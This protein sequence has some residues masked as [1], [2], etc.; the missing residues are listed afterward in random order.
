MKIFKN[1]Y[2]YLLLCMVCVSSV[3][4]EQNYYEI[5]SV[6]PTASQQEIIDAYRRLAIQHHP[7][8]GGSDEKMAEIN[9]AYIVLKDSKHRKEYDELLQ[10]KSNIPEG[11]NL[12]AELKAKMAR[13]TF[14]SAY[15]TAVG[16][17]ANPMTKQSAFITIARMGLELN[18]RQVRAI[19]H[20]VTLGIANEHEIVRLAAIQ[21]LAQYVDQLFVEDI[22][23]LLLLSS[24]MNKQDDRRL[25]EGRQ[26]K[27]FAMFRSSR[28]SSSAGKAITAQGDQNKDI[29]AH[30]GQEEAT[31][32]LG[33]KK[34]AENI[35]KQWFENHF[36]NPV[37]IS[38]ILGVI[39]NFD[40]YK[41][42]NVDYKGLREF[43]LQTIEGEESYIE[44][45]NS[46]HIQQL[47]EFEGSLKVRHIKYKLKVR[48][49]ISKWNRKYQSQNTALVEYSESRNLIRHIEE[50][51]E[52]KTDPV[53]YRITGVS[54]SI[55]YLGNNSDLP[56]ERIQQ[57]V[58]YTL[59]YVLTYQEGWNF[60]KYLVRHF[61]KLDMTK[62]L[63]TLI[64]LSGTSL[65]EPLTLVQSY[66]A[67]FSQQHFI[68][69]LYQ[70]MPFY[71]SR[72]GIRHGY[73]MLKAMWEYLDDSHKAQTVYVLKHLPVK[74]VQDGENFISIAENYL[75]EEDRRNIRGQ[76][77]AL[78]DNRASG[79]GGKACSKE[80]KQL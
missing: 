28:T 6:L 25:D 33:I 80:V 20:I 75:S 67:Y 79:G 61:P 14:Y 5:L 19:L 54:S 4:S 64:G 66:G 43:A 37:H 76:G 8:R 36:A 46:D 49:I 9:V 70:L 31:L 69:L 47:Q 57:I 56:V 71:Q 78:E 7:D 41:D 42:T 58:D 55:D 77:R 26:K 48:G 1:F 11:F 45:L 21:A 72:N 35:A 74:D 30:E 32:E 50:T 40:E 3:S 73:R 15:S 68:Q 27:P 53:L 23:L 29:T 51:E 22:N 38:Q 24:S 10:L 62:I 13:Q 18:N 2:I 39:A 17:A 44:K 63:D 65:S 12:E 34:R 59:S 60:L 16:D 52:E